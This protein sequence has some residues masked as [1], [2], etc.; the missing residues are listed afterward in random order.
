MKEW[1]KSEHKIRNKKVDVYLE[2]ACKSFWNIR[3]CTWIRFDGYVRFLHALMIIIKKTVI[4]FRFNMCIFTQLPYTASQF[5]CSPFLS[6]HNIAS[7]A[8][9]IAISQFQQ[10]DWMNVSCVIRDNCTFLLQ[11][12]AIENNNTTKW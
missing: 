3:P 1:E 12:H 9:I 8:R 2:N 11:W 6:M 4:L 10:C 7:H 5:H